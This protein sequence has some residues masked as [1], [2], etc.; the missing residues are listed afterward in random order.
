M[1]RK[2]KKIAETIKLVVILSEIK[3]SI[4]NAFINF[5]FLSRI[6][7]A[8]KNVEMLSRRICE[9]K[10]Q[11]LDLRCSNRNLNKKKVLQQ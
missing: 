4:K 2:R 6:I 8:V 11:R 9:I 10:S 1:Q 5:N 7:G 3:N